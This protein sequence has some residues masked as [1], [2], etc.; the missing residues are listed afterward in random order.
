MDNDEQR[1]K[2]SREPSQDTGD[3]DEE[4]DPGEAEDPDKKDSNDEE[5]NPDEDPN[6]G[7]EGTVA[8]FQRLFHNRS[9]T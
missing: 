8:Q 7:S 5:A 9:I 6:R 1:K 4:A 3:P 2:S